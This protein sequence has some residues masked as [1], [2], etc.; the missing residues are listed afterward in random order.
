MGRERIG[1]RSFIGQPTKPNNSKVKRKTE[2]R[3]KAI[4][5]HEE[6]S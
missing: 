1:A 2:K 6:F 5:L 4:S 3:K